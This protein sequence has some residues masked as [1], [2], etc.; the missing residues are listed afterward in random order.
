[1]MVD[2][3]CSDQGSPSF[4]CHQFKDFL[5]T[6]SRQ[7]FTVSETGQ[8]AVSLRLQIHKCE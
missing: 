5:S 1:M 2:D 8:Y 3:Y 6:F 4:V 7:I